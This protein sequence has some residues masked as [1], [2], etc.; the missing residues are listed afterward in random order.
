VSVVSR[1][2]NNF[3]QISLSDI[4]S[5][6]TELIVPPAALESV[7]TSALLTH[8]QLL[9]DRAVVA[10]KPS[11]AASNAG[12]LE[13]ANFPTG[14]ANTARPPI[15]IRV[16]EQQSLGSARERGWVEKHVPAAESTILRTRRRELMPKPGWSPS[17]FQC[18]GLSRKQGQSLPGEP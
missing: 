12:L 5:V 13:R 14:F 1:N 10:V 7:H 11:C 9:E 3:S 4:P 15:L 17:I 8:P 2:K 18:Q 16:I 6:T